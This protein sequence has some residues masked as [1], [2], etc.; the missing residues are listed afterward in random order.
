LG[1]RGIEVTSNR[2]VDAQALP[3]LLNQIP[4]DEQIESV[5]CDGAYNTEQVHTA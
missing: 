4:C 5:S 3:D 1:I 2:V